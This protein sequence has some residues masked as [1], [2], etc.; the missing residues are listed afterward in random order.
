MKLIVAVMGGHL[1]PVAVE[2]LNEAG[3]AVTRLASSGGFLRQSSSTLLISVAADQVEAALAVL[4]AVA[5][6]RAGTGAGAP[7][8]TVF[9]LNASQLLKA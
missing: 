5:Q 1:V 4:Q 9:V 8:A 3:F 7:G 6:Q 2:Q